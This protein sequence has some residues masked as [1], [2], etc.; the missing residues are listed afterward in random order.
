MDHVCMHGSQ[1]HQARV[2][3]LDLQLQLLQI[4]PLLVLEVSQ[5][6]QDPLP[7]EL[8]QGLTLHYSMERFLFLKTLCTDQP[9]IICDCL[10]LIE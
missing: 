4:L 8:I 2:F 3:V 7:F 9:F 1:V 10:G 6:L 5:L